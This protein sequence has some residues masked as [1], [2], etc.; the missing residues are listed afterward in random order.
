MLQVEFVTTVMS[1]ARTAPL[2]E[3]VVAFD[4]LS[5]IIIILTTVLKPVLQILL[6]ARLL[7]SVLVTLRAASVSTQP[8]TVLF[9]LT[10]LN[11][12]IKEAVLEVVRV[13]VT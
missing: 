4:V 3:M 6:L 9:V 12:F 1:V 2:P 5:V 11:S 10:L 13:V 8:L 7:G